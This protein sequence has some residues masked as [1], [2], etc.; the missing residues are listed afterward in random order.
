[1]SYKTLFN[2]VR[3][4]Q[5]TEEWVRSV[6]VIDVME[7]LHEQEDELDRLEALNAELVEVLEEMAS[8]ANESKRNN[9]DEFLEGLFENVGIS[10][11]LLAKAKGK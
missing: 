10:S 4:K 6:D 1:M 7:K 9:T 8:Y 3:R 2:K 11:K 5:K